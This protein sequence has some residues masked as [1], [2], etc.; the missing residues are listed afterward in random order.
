ML[1]FR[2]LY[3]YSDKFSA[4]SEYLSNNYVWY[5]PLDLTDCISLYEEGKLYGGLLDDV[6]SVCKINLPE[7][8]SIPPNFDIF[9][10]THRENQNEAVTELLK[11][12]RGIIEASPG[13]GKTVMISDVCS[14]LNN[15]KILILS[16]NNKPFQQIKNTLADACPSLNVS[17]YGDG[18]T[19]LSGDIVVGMR[20]S[21]VNINNDDFF[22]SIDVIIVDE[23]HHGV[24]TSYRK[25]YE[26]CVN[27]ERLYGVSATPYR[28]DELNDLLLPIFGKI[29]YTISYG[30][31][32]EANMLCPMVLI[33]E[34]VP[35]KEYPEPSYTA[36]RKMYD[37]LTNSVIQV[38]VPLSNYAI[39]MKKREHYKY[40]HDDYIMRNVERNLK[41]VN[42]ARNLNKQN[43]SCVIIVSKINH[44]NE[45]HKIM[46]EAVVLHGQC[47]QKYKDEVYKKLYN[48][49]ILTVISTL[50]DEA[51][52]IKTLDGVAIM[53]AGKSTVK[54][55]QRIRSTRVFEG[56]I[57]GVYTKKE[58]GY[59]YY[60]VDST[61]YFKTQSQTCLRMLKKEVNSSPHNKIYKI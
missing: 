48:K 38:E 20:Q 27:C 36:N 26:K 44:A 54:I 59:V 19:D 51:V 11:H 5:N 24:T 56:Y 42:F 3:C 4:Y 50:F 1:K 37:A 18:K 40:V 31:A 6:A 15:K 39:T 34:D 13:V 61:R 49:E 10:F 9:K 17:L 22:D 30:Q 7:N 28:D 47:N 33:L 43:K 25:I 21:V 2:G 8:T 23:C 12:Y 55:I 35:V 60:P 41:G 57:N 14:R 16:E 45:I 32:I 53:A 29:R 58:V 52:D 46:P